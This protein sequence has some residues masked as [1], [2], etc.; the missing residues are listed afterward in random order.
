[1]IRNK[2]NHIPHPT[3]NT[4]LEGRTHKNFDKR[5]RKTHTVNRMN[6]SFPNRWSFS[7]PNCKQQQHLF[8]LFSSLNY[9]KQNKTGSIMVNCYSTEHI[10]EY[11]IHTDMSCNKEEPQQKYRLGT[12]SNRILEGVGLKHGSKLC[13]LLPR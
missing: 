11:H 10:A 12:V 1:M 8:Y 4:K 3:L 9:R 2:C 5:S 7:Y 6:S 13:P